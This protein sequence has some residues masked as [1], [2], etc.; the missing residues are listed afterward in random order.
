MM[1]YVVITPAKDEEMVIPHILD[2]MV[3]QSVLPL[4]WVIVDDGSV[5]KT[6]E[7]AERYAQQHPWIKVVSS[8]KRER[9]EEGAPIIRAFYVGYELIKYEP[10]EFI[11]KLD[12][13][14]TLPHDYFKSVIDEFKNDGRVGLCGGYCVV[15]SK[16]KKTRE[17]HAS[18]HIRG[19]LKSVRR[20]CWEDIGGFQEVL[21]WDGLDEMN[22]MFFGWKTKNI[23]KEVIHHRPTASYYNSKNM[24]YKFGYSRYKNGSNIPLAFVRAMRRIGKHPIG[25]Y[26]FYYLYG[27]FSAL[28]RRE[29]KNVSPELAKFI[30]RFHAKRLFGLN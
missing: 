24:A 27:Y 29:D 7:I 23:E 16:G 9:R 6:R 18:Y 14:L 2:S 21:G 28:I 26:S 1:K 19:P 20:D 17:H 3:T 4:K 10:W 12:A 30:N 22:A 13:D 25:I 11:V 15:Y 5:D 8:R